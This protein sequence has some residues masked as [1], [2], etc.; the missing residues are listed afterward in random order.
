[1][2]ALEFIVVLCLSLLMIFVLLIRWNQS[3]ECTCSIARFAR[4]FTFSFLCILFI[5]FP[6]M[7]SNFG[8]ILVNKEPI[9]LCNDITMNSR[10]DIEN[11]GQIY[12][13]TIQRDNK[14]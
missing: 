7:G 4:D 3:M 9:I 6:K 12:H 8:F 14:D 13:N 5:Y 10:A 1:M 2:S 11:F